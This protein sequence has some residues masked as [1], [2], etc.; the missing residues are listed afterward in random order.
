MT[1]SSAR[2]FSLKV[3]RGG[4]NTHVLF[5]RACESGKHISAVPYTV[6]LLKQSHTSFRP[7][8]PSLYGRK[9][10]IRCGM[11]LHPWAENSRS[12]LGT[13]SIALA[14]SSS[15]AS[16]TSMP[17][18]AKASRA[19]SLMWRYSRGRNGTKKSIKWPDIRS[20]WAKPP[21]EENWC[22]RKGGDKVSTHRR[23]IIKQTAGVC[24]ALRRGRRRTLRLHRFGPESML[25]VL[26]ANVLAILTRVPKIQGDIID[27]HSTDVAVETT[28]PSHNVSALHAIYSWMYQLSNISRIESARVINDLCYLQC[29]TRP[30][31]ALDFKNDMIAVLSNVKCVTLFFLLFFD[32]TDLRKRK[33]APR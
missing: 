17:R 9:K 27:R 24:A 20:L 8:D 31:S 29:K 33:M 19:H 28:C 14:T 25:Q 4:W 5:L 2:S 7:R 30:A 23:Q 6:G 22:V 1:I 18:A 11:D 21:E 12:S 32:P 13:Y 10:L 16:S 26:H 15:V 3:F